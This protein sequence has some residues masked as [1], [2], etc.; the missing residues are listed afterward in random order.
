MGNVPFME[1]INMMLQIGMFLFCLFYLK[2]SKCGNPKKQRLKYSMQKMERKEI[3]KMLEAP[4]NIQSNPV[5]LSTSTEQ[6]DNDK[7]PVFVPFESKQ[8]FDQNNNQWTNFTNKKCDEYHSY[9]THPINPFY[10]N[11]ENN[12]HNDNHYEPEPMDVDVWS[13]KCSMND[14]GNNINNDFDAILNGIHS[15]DLSQ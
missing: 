13:P 8:P 9:N 5:F 14:I 1:W 15:L 7:H 12:D 4:R 6:K 2:C 11:T 10:A 3:L